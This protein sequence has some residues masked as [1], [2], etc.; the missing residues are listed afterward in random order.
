MHAEETNELAYIEDLSI[1]HN[2]AMW[3]LQ[4]V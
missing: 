2:D 1:H 4:I 3:E